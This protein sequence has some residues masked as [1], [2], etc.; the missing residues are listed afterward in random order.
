MRSGAERSLSRCSPRS[1]SSSSTSWAVD[2]RDEHLPAVAGGGDA[3]GA[4]DVA[5]D[6]ALLG[7]ERRPRVQADPHLDRA[8][9][10]RLGHRRRG[11]ERARRGREGEEEGV[12]LRVD[13]DAA[14]ARRR[15]RGSRAGARRAPPRSASAPSSCSSLVEPSTSVKRKVTVPEGR[16]PRTGV[17]MRQSKVHVTIRAADSATRSPSDHTP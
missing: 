5:A 14:L 3:G 6:V 4:V 11:G 16:S 10:E 17:I 2:G 12:A 1:A 9:G 8:G 7:Q 15:P 13:L